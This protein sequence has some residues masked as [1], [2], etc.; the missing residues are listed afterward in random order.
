MKAFL[1]AVALAAGLGATALAATE[2][3]PAA[4][5]ERACFS[6]RDWKGWKARDET[7]MYLKV[8][9]HDVYEVG[10]KSGCRRMQ[11]ISA[12]LITVFRGSTTICGPLDLDIKVTDSAGTPA[13]A[14]IASSVRKLSDAE[15]KAIPKQ[16]QP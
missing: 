11:D 15:A 5:S 9:L 14:C 7:T 3:Q 6:A 10:F 8:G 16:F 1:M 13:V 12:Q 2:T 4:A